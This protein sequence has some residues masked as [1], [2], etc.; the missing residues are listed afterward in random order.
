MHRSFPGTF[1]SGLGIAQRE[2]GAPGIIRTASSGR[3]S[4]VTYDFQFEG[5]HYRD[6]EDHNPNLIVGTNS[7][8]DFRVNNESRTISYHLR[9][10][11]GFGEGKQQ[12]HE[13]DFAVTATNVVSALTAGLDASTTICI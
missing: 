10:F 13:D 7:L 11:E 6:S 2:R 4:G 5:K 9:E 3:H 1:H 8:R 12:R